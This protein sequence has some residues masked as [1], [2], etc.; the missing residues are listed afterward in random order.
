MNERQRQRLLDR[1]QRPSATVGKQMVDEL[2][3]QGTTIDVQEFVFECKRLEA[4]PESER[5]AIEEMKTKLKRERLARKQ[6]ID[7][8]EIAV[9]EG[10]RLVRSIHGIDRALTALEGLDSPNIEEE[11]RLK[12]L[13]DARELISLIRQRP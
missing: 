13:K 5:D 1:I 11:V 8:G 12:K 9:E 7:R 4:I 2:T 6:R 10:E 3:I